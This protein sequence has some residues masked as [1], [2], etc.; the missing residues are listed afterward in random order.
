MQNPAPGH[1]A[2]PTTHWT[3]VIAAGG[4]H[5]S[6]ERGVALHSRSGEVDVVLETGF[7]GTFQQSKE[8]SAFVCSCST[9]D[10]NDD[11]VMWPYR[12]EMEKVVPVASQQHA[13]ML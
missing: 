12:C 8:R 3:L 13:T 9:A 1:N 4:A 11:A 7:G 2:F 6:L 5:S 10:H